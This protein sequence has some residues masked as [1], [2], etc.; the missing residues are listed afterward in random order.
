LDSGF[1]SGFSAFAFTMDLFLFLL[2]PPGADP[3]KSRELA[4]QALSKK[5]HWSLSDLKQMGAFTQQVA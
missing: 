3:G 5:T 2:H 4:A 1:G